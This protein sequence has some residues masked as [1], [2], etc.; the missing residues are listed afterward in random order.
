MD[1]CTGISETGTSE[2]PDITGAVETGTSM[3]SNSSTAFS[4][5]A[6]KFPS[7]KQITKKKVAKIAVVLVEITRTGRTK[8]GI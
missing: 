2:L 6:V 4:V 3:F 8:Y 1:C 7:N 5:P